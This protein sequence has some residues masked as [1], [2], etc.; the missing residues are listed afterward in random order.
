MTSVKRRFGFARHLNLAAQIIL[1]KLDLVGS[2]EA[3]KVKATSSSYLDKC[4][5]NIL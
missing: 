5:C 1:N 4:D 3:I 2:E